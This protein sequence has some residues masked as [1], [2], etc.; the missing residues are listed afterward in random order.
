M[1]KSFSF[2]HL[3]MSLKVMK[4]F[5]LNYNLYSFKQYYRITNKFFI[6]KLFFIHKYKTSKSKLIII[7]IHKYVD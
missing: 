3:N 7:K 4:S 2:L 6:E 5:E 1:T